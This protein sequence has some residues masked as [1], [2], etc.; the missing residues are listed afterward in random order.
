VVLNPGS[1]G[2]PLDGDPRVS[3]AVIRNGVAEIRRVEYDIEQAAAGIREMGLANDA[4]EALIA[5]LKTGTS[6]AGPA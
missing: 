6:L 1:V 4:A 5:I 3:Y 2:Q